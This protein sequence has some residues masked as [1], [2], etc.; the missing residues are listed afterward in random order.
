MEKDADLKLVLD[1]T[2]LSLDENIKSSILIKPVQLLNNK[3]LFF[4]IKK[5]KLI[6]P[7]NGALMNSN[8]I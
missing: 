2:C 7:R 6:V 1:I 5:G 8:F 4:Q 3:Q